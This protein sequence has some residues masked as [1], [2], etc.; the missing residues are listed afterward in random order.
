MIEASVFLGYLK[1]L[2]GDNNCALIV[3]SIPVSP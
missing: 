1:G 2:L 3:I